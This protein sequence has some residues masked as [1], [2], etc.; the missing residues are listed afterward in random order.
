MKTSKQFRPFGT[1]Y[2]LQI[3]GKAKENITAE[4]G[5]QIDTAVYTLDDEREQSL[6]GK[7]DALRLSTVRLQPEGAS[8]E[9]SEYK[10]TSRCI[11]NVKLTPIPKESIISGGQTQEEIDKAMK[12]LTDQFSKL[13]EDITEK[14]KGEP[15]KVQVKPNPVLIIQPTSRIPLY[16]KHMI[17]D[18]ITEEPLE[19]EELETYISNLV[20]TDKKWDSTKKHIRVTLDCQAANKDIYRT[21]EP[22]PTSEELRHELRGSN[23][24]S[25]LDFRNCFHQFEIDPAARKFYTFRSPWGIYHYKMVMGISPVSREIQKQVRDTTKDCKNAINIKDDILAH[26]KG[27]DHDTYLRGFSLPSKKKS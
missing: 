8:H 4:K 17:Q 27:K 22:M 7:E 9:V 23:R 15:I 19:F 3:K 6:L 10:E 25:V 20:K 11:T 21:H 1:N 12:D 14:F 24:F 13:F 5:T 18:D 26:D 16:Y 2:H